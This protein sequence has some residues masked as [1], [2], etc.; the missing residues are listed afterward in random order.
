[1]SLKF[2]VCFPVLYAL[3]WEQ[4]VLGPPLR[5]FLPQ[6]HPVLSTCLPTASQPLRLFLCCFQLPLYKMFHCHSQTMTSVTDEI[7]ATLTCWALTWKTRQFKKPFFLIF[8]QGNQ[9]QNH[10][11]FHENVPSLWES[12]ESFCCLPR[13]LSTEKITSAAKDQLPGNFL[14]TISTGLFPVCLKRG[15]SFCSGAVVKGNELG[16]LLYKTKPVSLT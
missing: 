12:T 9:M 10:I 13:T 1:M 4:A 3:Q 8:L 14:P 2:T 7:S 16:L 11:L 5:L 6:C 15:M